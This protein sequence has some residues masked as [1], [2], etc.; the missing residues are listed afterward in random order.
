MYGY[1]V[2]IVYISAFRLKDN[3]KLSARNYTM[4]ETFAEINDL[5]LLLVLCFCRDVF[6]AF[7]L[8]EN[9]TSYINLI[10]NCTQNKKKQNH[11]N[12]IV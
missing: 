2:H 12:K 7:S 4:T 1:T 8:S 6:I 11:A 5:V 10:N 3:H 9:A